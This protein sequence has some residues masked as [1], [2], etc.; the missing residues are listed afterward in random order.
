MGEPRLFLSLY[1]DEDVSIKIVRSLSNRGFD[2]LHSVEA[3]MAGKSDDEQPRFA[4]TRGSTIVTHNRTDFEK[5][6]I[7]CL[8]EGKG[9]AG[10]I[11]ATR[12]RGSEEAI[13]RLLHILDTVTPDEM[14]QQLRY[15]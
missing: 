5:L 9:H 4:S 11:V 15:I 1:F 8:A 14:M 12:R 13:R 2:T 10:I 6:H 7:R 3:G